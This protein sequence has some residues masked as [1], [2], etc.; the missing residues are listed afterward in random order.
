MNKKLNSKIEQDI[1]WFSEQVNNIILEITSQRSNYSEQNFG[2]VM[3]TQY[4][5]KLVPLVEELSEKY[6]F[7]LYR[8]EL[9]IFNKQLQDKLEA[10]LEIILQKMNCP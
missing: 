6:S 3:F 10:G 4:M 7:F 8:E 2:V 5:P 9:K 1:N